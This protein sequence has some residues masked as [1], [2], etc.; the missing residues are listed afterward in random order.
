MRPG[1]AVNGPIVRLTVP[2]VPRPQGSL[3]IITNQRT[4]QPFAKNSDAMT[5]YRNRV[6]EAWQRAWARPALDCPVGVRLEFTFPRP[7]SHFGTGRNRD[8]VKPSAPELWHT[9]TPDA[10]KLIRLQLDGLVI[11]GVLRDDSLVSLVRGEKRWGDPQALVEVFV[12]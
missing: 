12:L 8:R 10:D 1:A 3:K 5:E 7:K 2:G 11:G 9:Q 4:G 6:V